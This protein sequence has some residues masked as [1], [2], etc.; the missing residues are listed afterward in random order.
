VTPFAGLLVIGG[1]LA[2]LL[3]A[4]GACQR[5]WRM[6]P[7]LA[8]KLFHLGGGLAGLSLPW[9][10]AQVWPVLALTGSFSA[11]LIAVRRVHL[12]RSGIGRVL[13][14]IE[15]FSLGELCF[16][17]SVCI[18]YLACREDAL[19][20]S[21]PILILTFADAGAA[22]VG[23]RY[24]SLRYRTLDGMK[25]VEGSAAFF[26]L[27]FLSAY[28]PILLWAGERGAAPVLI[29]LAVAVLATVAEAVSWAGLDNISVPVTS[30]LLL[31]VLL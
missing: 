26:L 16:P 30:F 7:E 9:L 4:I 2:G 3:L 29:A 31:R 20:Y 23:I 6:H 28:L 24:G 8:R 17:V 13:G 10:F 5:R 18:L 1:G 21:V 11:V 14:G 22:L 25:T 27:A 15:R 19:L 12:L